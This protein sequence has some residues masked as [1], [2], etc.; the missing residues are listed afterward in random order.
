MTKVE[1]LCQTPLVSHPGN[2]AGLYTNLCMLAIFSAHVT[3][4]ASCRRTKSLD[5][6]NG[7]KMKVSRFLVV[8]VVA[9]V[10]V[11][12][13]AVSMV[14]MRQTDS[15]RAS[16][17]IN[18]IAHNAQTNAGAYASIETSDPSVTV[19]WAYNRIASTSGSKYVEIGWIKDQAHSEDPSPY[20]AYHDGSA[21]DSERIDV[22]L[23]IGTSY[24]Y[25][26]KHDT[27][28]NWDIY[29]NELN[30]A[31]E[32]VNIGTSST[33]SVMVG[34]EVTDTSDDIGDSDDTG[35]AY[36]STSDGNFYSL[37]GMAQTNNSPANYSWQDLVGCG[38]WRFYDRP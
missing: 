22:N 20:W 28:G 7:G 1:G 9:L 26:V 5:N 4:V 25:Q 2:F 36:R 34:A 38:N 10:A 33:A 21:S 24:N 8:G 37:C 3:F 31:D 32:T 13:V 14:V 16:A 6:M 12:A 15:A 29:F 35:T 30:V 19:N 27:G 23:S 11:A 17:L 18:I